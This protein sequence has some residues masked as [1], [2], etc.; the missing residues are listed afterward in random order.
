MKADKTTFKSTAWPHSSPK[1]GKNLNKE[2]ELWNIPATHLK[3][4]LGW[5]SNQTHFS[6]IPYPFLKHTAVSKSF[7]GFI[8]LRYGYTEISKANRYKA[9][10]IFFLILL[11]KICPHSKQDWATAINQI[12]HS[13]WTSAGIKR[14]AEKPWA[15]SGH[16]K[17]QLA[18]GPWSQRMLI[19]FCLA[20]CSA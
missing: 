5:S 6:V 18:E 17:K 13:K 9:Q 16:E 20:P 7:Y 3:V 15:V 2:S 10:V 11:P 1:T 4:G 8:Q 12:Y 14:P 19:S